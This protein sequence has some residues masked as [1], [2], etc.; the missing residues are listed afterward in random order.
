MRL[1]QF[2]QKTG[3][4]K[5]RSLAKEICDRGL[6]D[7]SGRRAKAAHEVSPKD[8]L[9]VRFHDRRCTYTV[10]GIPLGSVRKEDR[11]EYVQ[12]TGEERFHEE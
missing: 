10:L 8:I 6:V 9:T 5:R 3:I 11:V 12:L 2:L 1:D 4:V 7:I